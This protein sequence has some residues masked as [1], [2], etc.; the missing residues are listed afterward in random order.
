MSAVPLAPGDAV[1]RIA[2]RGWVVG[3][4]LA[5]LLYAVFA[6]GIGELWRVW[7]ERPEYSYGPFIPCLTAFLIW[8]RR[9]RL[10]RV[11][12]VGSWF[13]P[14]L[15]ALAVLL[16]LAG[17]LATSSILVEYGLVVAIF[18]IALS[19]L[20][21]PGLRLLF[22]PLLF[23]FFM[24]PLPEFLLQSLSTHLQAVSSQLGVAFIRFCDISVHLDGNVIDLGT[25]KLQV[26]EAC[27][28]LRYLFAMLTLGF[29]VAY[30]FKG[31]LW[32]RI[33][34]FLAAFPITVLMNS[35]RIGL[36][37]VTVEYFGR[38]AAEG[39]LHEFEGLGIFMGCLI[40]LVALMWGLARIGR[41]PRP[42]R[43]VFGLELPPRTPAGAAVRDRPIPAALVVA[44]GLLLA[45]AIATAALPER[46]PL[47]PAR[48][49][50]GAFPMS[51]DAW[52][53]RSEKLDPIYLDVLKPSDYLI[54]DYRS[55]QR[56]LINLYIA[57]YDAQNREASSHSP[58]LCIP[59]GGWEIIELERRELPDV[60]FRGQ[61][62]AVNRAVIVKGEYRQLVYYWFQQRGRNLTNEYVTKTYILWDSLTR[63]RSDGAMVRLVTP[64]RG[65]EPQDAADRRLTQ[66]AASLIPTLAAYVPE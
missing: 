54:A 64:I 52:R 42:L 48:Q 18:G 14:L 5:A 10:E 19:Y 45:T 35:F 31:P 66:F 2:L 29:V 38:S 30:F 8:Q 12:A 22:M 25:M 20:G 21:V 36:V 53:G 4:V 15:V 50:F 6:V 40:L 24:I 9:D 16:R 43:A 56:D 11:P 37:G 23:L 13:G 60:R 7:T 59:A 34:I 57:Y 63:N 28:G 41:D 44:A 51:V 27:S 62:L 17:D 61:P 46:K 49:D 33:V 58:R 47:K 1:W 39:V 55:P 26:A 32:K 65:G 3:A